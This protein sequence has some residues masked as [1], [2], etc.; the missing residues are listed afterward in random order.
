MRSKDI[1]P[2]SEYRAD[3]AGQFR[4]VQETGRPLFVTNNGHAAAVMLSP[5]TYDSLMDEI[6]LARSLSLIAKGE[7]QFDSGDKQDALKGL[8]KIKAKLKTAQKSE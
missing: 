1:T 2:L 5:E 7:D 4:H 6:E 3:L 8:S